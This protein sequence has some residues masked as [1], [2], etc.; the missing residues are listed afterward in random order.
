MHYPYLTESA[1]HGVTLDLL[2]V[3][4]DELDTGV[5]PEDAP[6]IQ[7]S[8]S[9]PVAAEEDVRQRWLDALNKC[10]YYTL[11]SLSFPSHSGSYLAH[12]PN[13]DLELDTRQ[14]VMAILSSGLPLPKSPSIQIAEV[15]MGQASDT[16]QQE[17]EE[18]GWW[19]LR[20]QQ[21]LREMQRQDV[22]LSL[23]EPQ[24]LVLPSRGSNNATRP[25]CQKSASGHG[26][27][28]DNRTPRLRDP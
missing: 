10:R 12:G 27:R 21:V 19:S 26:I 4:I 14:S 15:S 1:D 20:F 18:R 6:V 16:T 2:P 5:I 24:R 9:F 17:R 8:L 25:L 23:L 11:R 28:M 22:P 7:L 13:V 3:G